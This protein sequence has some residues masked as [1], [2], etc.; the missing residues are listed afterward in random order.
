M[1]LVIQRIMFLAACLQ[2][3]PSL[4][5]NNGF[6]LGHGW[7]KYTKNHEDGYFSGLNDVRE[8]E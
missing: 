1:L 8:S 6:T 2:I 4:K 5:Q 3:A 7:R